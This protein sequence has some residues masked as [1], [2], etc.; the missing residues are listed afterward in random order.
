V[1]SGVAPVEGESSPIMPGF[2]STM[3]DA[4]IA[5]LLHYLRSRFSDQPAWSDIER[6][7]AEARR[8]QTASLNTGAGARPASPD[9]AQRDK[10]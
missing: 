9:Q 3:N 6:T 4:Q 10:R 2:A 1:L 5:V 8:T 7:I